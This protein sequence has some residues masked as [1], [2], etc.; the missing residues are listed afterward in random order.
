ML[1][2]AGPGRGV[3]ERAGLLL[4]NAH[5]SWTVFASNAAGTTSR[6]VVEAKI[7]TVKSESWYGGFAERG[8]DHHRQAVHE[9][10]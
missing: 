5:Q 2:G 6:L 4:R 8:I 3:V 1:R 10:V 9:G 7:D